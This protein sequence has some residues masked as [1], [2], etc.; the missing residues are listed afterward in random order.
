MKHILT[1]LIL[2][3]LSVSSANAQLTSFK[4]AYLT[5]GVSFPASP[6]QFYDYWKPGYGATVGLEYQLAL[7]YSLVVAAEYDRFGFDSDRFF[8]R[9]K[10]EGGDYSV[11]G[12]AGTIM[13]L[14][15]N[16]HYLV[17]GYEWLRPSFVGGIGILFTSTGQ[18]TVNYAGTKET[19]GSH[20]SMVVCVP[21]GLRLAKSYS[22]NIDI[23]LDLQYVIGL[24]KAQD[25]NSNYSTMKIGVAIVP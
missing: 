4:R 25:V 24:T 23:V 19:R 12:A 11:S 21:F 2:L 7:Q 15:G 14:S 3:A 5:T 17:P 9:L 20:S 1:F 18:A 6:D 22:N 8:K 13:M 10:L 16:L